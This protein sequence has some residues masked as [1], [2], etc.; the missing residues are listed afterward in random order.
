MRSNGIIKK[1]EITKEKHKECTSNSHRY[2]LIDAAAGSLS[3]NFIAE[4]GLR[5]RKRAEKSCGRRKS[6]GDHVAISESRRGLVLIE[7][8]R[9]RRTRFF[10]S[11][12]KNNAEKRRV[13]ALTNNKLLSP[14]AKKLGSV[15]SRRRY[16]PTLQCP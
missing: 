12:N 5:G 9:I 14:R 3:H 11:S 6:V 13:V 7:R 1:K 2:N 15:E 16:Y 8:E 10:A 4:T